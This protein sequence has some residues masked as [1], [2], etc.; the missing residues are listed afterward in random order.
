MEY[1]C[2]EVGN[3]MVRNVKT[4]NGKFEN[5]KVASSR[6]I[7]EKHGRCI[8]EDILKFAD[9]STHEWVYFKASGTAVAIA[10]FTKNNK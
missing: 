3:V 7:Y 2:A 8:I 10:A 1:R 4:L 5:V 9:G 6:V